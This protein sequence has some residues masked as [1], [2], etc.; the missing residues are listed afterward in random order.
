[1][2]LVTII[3]TTDRQEVHVLEVQA[4]A[5]YLKYLGD[6]ATPCPN[7]YCKRPFGH[8]GNHYYDEDDALAAPLNRRRPHHGTPRRL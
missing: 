7:S 6:N 2:A 8:S 3:Y 5:A 1:M 4:T